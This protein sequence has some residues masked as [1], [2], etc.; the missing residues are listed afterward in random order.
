MICHSLPNVAVVWSIALMHQLCKPLANL[1]T[2]VTLGGWM[3]R[4]EGAGKGEGEE[5][6]D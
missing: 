6:E 1:E 4:R 5:K 2:A 3:R